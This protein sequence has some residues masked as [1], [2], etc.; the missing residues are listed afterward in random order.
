MTSMKIGSNFET[1]R[2][3]VL[4]ASDGHHDT[5]GLAVW[6]FYNRFLF[7]AKRTYIL[8]AVGDQPQFHGKHAHK[9]LNQLFICVQGEAI[10]DLHVTDKAKPQKRFIL[11]VNQGLHL[12][13]GYWREVQ[14]R[15][16]TILIVLADMPFDESD[17]IRDWAIY[18]EW[19]S[20]ACK[21]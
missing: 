1:L 16:N 5:D 21:K 7:I 12:T 6:E 2:E 10:I 3:P 9:A 15:K 13:S 18:Q 11:G 17:Y 14:L 8:S 4:M 20:S 19:L